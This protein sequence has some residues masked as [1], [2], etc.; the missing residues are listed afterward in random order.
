LTVAVAALLAG[1]IDQEKF[2]VSTGLLSVPPAKSELAPGEHAEIAFQAVDDS[3]NG[4]PDQSVEVLIT[5]PSRLAFAGD[6]AGSNRV[7]R[8]TT[9]AE[10]VNGAELTGAVV[11]GVDVPA[12]AKPGTVNVTASLAGDR[13]GSSPKTRWVTLEI[14]AAGGA[15]GQ[16]ASAGEGGVAV[17]GGVGGLAGEGGVAGQGGA[18]EG[19]VAGVGGDAA[20]GGDTGMAGVANVGGAGN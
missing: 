13:V 4:V 1:W 2:G 11:I 7:V 20:N 3:R 5:D 9:R 19:V 14:T 6:D 8:A 10:L 12:D 17:E 15:G 16:G 18:G